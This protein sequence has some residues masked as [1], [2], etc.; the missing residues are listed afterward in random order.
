MVG[1]PG[2]SRDLSF[3]GSLTHRGRRRSQGR[4][5]GRQSVGR[6]RRQS[7]QDFP[8]DLPA[9]FHG[10]IQSSLKAKA[11]PTRLSST[12]L[13]PAGRRW[14]ARGWPLVH[15]SPP[16]TTFFIMHP[17][18]ELPGCISNKIRMIILD[19][20][21]VNRLRTF[22]PSTKATNVSSPSAPSSRSPG[23][24]CCARSSPGRP[25]R[26]G[27]RPWCGSRDRRRAGP[28]VVHSSG[29]P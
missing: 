5:P 19:R 10:T 25:P 6:P 11:V 4:S 7:R 29:S 12:G 9:A 3:V 18:R 17:C 27:A 2:T 1:P 21:V 16:D 22:G 8:L 13:Y 28:A 15:F 20:Q 24:I 23:T 14:P 26:T